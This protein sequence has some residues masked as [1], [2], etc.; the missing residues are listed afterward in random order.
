MIYRKYWEL[1]T[2]KSLFLQALFII[3]SETTSISYKPAK[4]FYLNITSKKL[5]ISFHEAVSA[6]AL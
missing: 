4:L 6:F 3:V 1:Y 2:K 5:F